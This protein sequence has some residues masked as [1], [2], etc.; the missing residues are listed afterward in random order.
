MFVLSEL[1]INTS[2]VLSNTVLSRSTADVLYLLKKR[3][4]NALEI[5]KKTKY[6]S[7]TIRTALKTLIDLKLV[8]RIPN[9][10]DMR[11]CYYHA[12]TLK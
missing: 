9:L 2:P 12:T 5:Q 1:A 8:E 3:P 6:S 10:Q 4:L 11:T 7:R